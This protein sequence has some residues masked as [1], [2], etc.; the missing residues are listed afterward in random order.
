MMGA[1][2]P[3]QH[4]AIP[5]QRGQLHSDAGPSPALRRQDELHSKDRTRRQPDV[6]P[7]AIAIWKVTLC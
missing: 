5:V 7:E 4:N 1:W 6:L 3:L 2:A